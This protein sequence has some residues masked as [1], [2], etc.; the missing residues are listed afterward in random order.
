MINNLL[1]NNLCKNQIFFLTKEELLTLL[2]DNKDNYYNRFYNHD[3][4][5]RN[6][7]NIDQY[8]ELIHHSVSEFHHYQK[9]KLKKSIQQADLFLSNLNLEWFKSKKNSKIE[10]IIGCVK[11]KLYEN[12]L[13]HTRNNAIIISSEKVNEYDINRLTKT[14]IHE[15]VHIYQKMYK[16]DISIFLL[17]NHFRIYK[18]RSPNDNIRANPDLDNWIYIDNKNNIY[19]AVYNK[20]PQSIED[21]LYSPYDEQSYEHPFEKMAIDIEN[22]YKNK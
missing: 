7:N 5:A 16:E 8:K 12:G 11:G 10:W 3:F 9:K 18:E 6:I 1:K 20:D 21:I 19:R 14:F 17:K 22:I 4:S 15:R 2:I 13:P